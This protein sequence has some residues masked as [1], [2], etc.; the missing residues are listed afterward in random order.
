M[1][2]LTKRLIDGLEPKSS[3]YF[4]WDDELPG[5]GVRVW[6]TGRKVYVAQYRAGVRTRRVKVGTYG[7]L[8]VE[9]AR[10]EAKGILGDV[11]RGEDPQEDR[12]TRRKSLTV[13]QL[14]DNY[15]QAAERGLI[16][17]KG[18]K[19]KK[20][21]TLYTDRGRIDRHIRPLLGNKLVRDMTQADVARF[22]RDVASG[23]TAV[24]EKTDRKRGKAIVEGGTGTAARTAGLLG[25]ILSFAV[26]EGVIPF[27][28]AT[29][30][31]RPADNRRQRRLTADEYKALGKA[32]VAAEADAETAQ[33]IKGAWLL[34]LTGCRLGEVENLK[35]AE[36]DDDGGCFR[37]E[38]SKEGA[39]VRP[40]G[41]PVFD[42]LATIEREKDNPFVLT[43]LR[44][45]GAFGGMPGAWRRIVKRA[46]LEGIT[47]HTLR[48]SYASVAGDLGFTESTIAAML[49]HAAGSVTSRYVHH[50]DSVLI[51]AADKVART[52]HGMM[53][54]AEGKVVQLPSRKRRA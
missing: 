15:L 19:A 54:G 53:T 46:E 48:H 9:E 7:P 24:V 29:G 23:K 11:A 25:G 34:A 32:L 5:F 18:G 45:E 17:G 35:W 21:S 47:P 6:P 4:E 26:S 39:S 1:A 50:L 3:D 13:S 42:V 44:G 22:I 52:I 49:G 16:M 2:K 10:K 51:A 43:A 30:V 40:I 31:K 28:P 12:V 41:R 38:D 36:V 27:N 33:G 14:C 20:A 8:T 37:L